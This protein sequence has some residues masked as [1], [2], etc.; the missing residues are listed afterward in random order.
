MILVNILVGEFITGNSVKIDTH[1]T[2]QCS[3]HENGYGIVLHTKGSY[4]QPGMALTEEA[5]EALLQAMKAAK[6]LRKQHKLV[7]KIKAVIWSVDIV[8]GTI[9]GEVS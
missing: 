3:V 9:Q 2:A 7:Q 5:F 4:S 1:R 8:D 6:K